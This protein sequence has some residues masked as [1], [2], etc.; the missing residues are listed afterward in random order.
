MVE[1][2]SNRKGYE[3]YFQGGNGGRCVRLT[4]LVCRFCVDW[5]L[6]TYILLLLLMALK[7]FQFDLGFPYN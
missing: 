6:G 2:A 4:T 1:S 5:L 7:P 3:E